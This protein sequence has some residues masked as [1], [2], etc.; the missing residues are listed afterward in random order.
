MMVDP[1]DF[2][3]PRRLELPGVSATEL[4]EGF[5]CPDCGRTA[6]DPHSVA[7]GYCNTC[8]WWTGDPVLAGQGQRSSDKARTRST[9]R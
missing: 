4:R 1:D 5:T 8:R 2:E 9:P 6:H 3:P 7:E